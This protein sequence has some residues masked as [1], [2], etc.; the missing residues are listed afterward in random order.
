MRQWS[1]RIGVLVAL[2]A[3]MSVSV[4]IAP[5]VQAAPMPLNPAVWTKTQKSAKQRYP[6]IAVI[7]SVNIRMSDGTVLK[8]DV[9]RPADAAGRATADKNP[10][11]VNLTPYNKLLSM[12][13]AGATNIP[14][15]SEPLIKFLA[16]FNLSGTP[17]S[18]MEHLLK[19]ANGGLTSVFSVDP[20]LVRSGYTQ[21]VVDVRGTGTSQGVWDVFG[22]R[23]QQDTL[24]V[25]E[26]AR[27]R[28]YSNG[29]LGMMG[30]SYSAIN[31]LQVAAKHP[32]GL[33]AIFPAAP[34]TDLV[35]DVVAPGSGYGAGFLALWLFA[36]NSLKFAPDLPAL[37]R[38]EFDVRWLMDRINNPAVFGK[39]F[40]DG[41][42]AP[43]TQSLSGRSAEIVKVNSVYRKA[44]LTD[45]S[46]IQIPT[47]ITGG[48][49]DLFTNMEWRALDQLSSLPAE[50]K[51]LVMSTG[52]HLTN[53]WDMGNG[54]NEPP[55]MGVFAR[56]WFDKW[57]KGINNGIDRY[58]NATSH[59]LGSGRWVQSASMPR[60]GQ[61]HR[62]LYLTPRRSGTS[63][64]SVR[65]GSLSGAAPTTKAKWTVAPGITTLCSG[66][67]N[68]DQIGFL[69]P[70]DFCVKDNRIAERGALT[71]T[72]P[73]VRSTTTV[74][75]PL[76][77]H[78]RTQVD[79]KDGFYAAVVS[80][81]APNGVSTPITTG[82][83]TVSIRN[84]MVK[85]QSGY[86]PNG[87]VV[88]PIY[89]LDAFT[90]DTVRP[91][92][93]QFLDIGLLGTDA[94]LRPGHR[95][96]VSVYAFNAPRA[97]SFGPITHDTGLKPEHV[98][99][100]PNSPSWLQ[101]PSDRPIGG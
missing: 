2:V 79:A 27:K 50:K 88:D 51:K 10:V 99:L 20:N 12:I 87:D 6:G 78:L 85:A 53:G 45:A 1:R 41:L 92:S 52:E 91:G 23:E 59:P 3:V 15:L 95:L 98:L 93:S 42:L 5:P 22:N 70:L 18:G 35:A 40:F 14:Y 44:L 65:D 28:A 67:A 58:P 69:S 71:F 37:L 63:P 82:S 68:R 101:V 19:V 26:W 48:W 94:I 76:N 73:A 36:V 72:S 56:A 32:K 9:Y 96:R 57:L 75:G 74:N 80:D 24:E 49:N 43:N 62:R 89:A 90:R 46:K 21:V 25:L 47:F 7:P 60:P 13:T 77:L 83:M 33:K 34:M 8:A 97:V 66:D 17:I 54:R 11:I 30:Y 38:G 64:T 81:V 39:E 100:D 86:A 29:D 55:A 31:Q 16:S 61:E 84:Q 4:A